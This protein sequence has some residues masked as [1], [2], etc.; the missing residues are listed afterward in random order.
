MTGGGPPRLPS[1][2]PLAG[3]QKAAERDL[4]ARW[5]KGRACRNGSAAP[6]KRQA[7]RVLKLS[8]QP[9]LGV[10]CKR[11]LA[12]LSLAVAATLA[13]SAPGLANR[14]GLQNPVA[15]DRV[16]LSGLKGLIEDEEPQHPDAAASGPRS[17]SGTAVKHRTVAP[18][19]P[20][21]ARPPLDFSGPPRTHAARA[22]L[23]RAPPLA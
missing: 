15:P 18:E 3:P 23:T 9:K 19:P 2:R 14:S 12:V 8:A 4:E 5:P 13:A 20:R 22:G 21:T 17:K 10:L 1:G 6:S 16:L 11:L 7:T